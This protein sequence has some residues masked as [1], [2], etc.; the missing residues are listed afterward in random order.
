M[1][2]NLIL[3]TTDPRGVATVTVNNAERRNALG[4]SGK[5]ELAAGLCRK[6]ICRPA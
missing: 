6:R 2:S 5:R 3:A 1:S 4:N